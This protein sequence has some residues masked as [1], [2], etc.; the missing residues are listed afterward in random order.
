MKSP[1][2][3]SLCEEILRLDAEATAGPW[4]VGAGMSGGSQVFRPDGDS[5]VKMLAHG[6]PYLDAENAE[7][8][9]RYRTLAP[10]L[11]RAVLE[12]MGEER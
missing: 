12:M 2:L 4:A 11:A 7:I 9:A 6:W 1:E 10:Q 3:K 5:V 8:I